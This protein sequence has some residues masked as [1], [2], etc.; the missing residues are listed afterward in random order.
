MRSLR[1]WITRLLGTM[2]GQRSDRDLELELRLHVELAEEQARRRADDPADAARTARL[3]TGNVPVAMDALRDQRGLPWLDA[4]RADVVFGWRQLKRHRAATAAAILSLGLAIGATTAAFR[5]VDALLLRPLPVA[6]PD[7]LFAVA[8]TFLDAGKQIDTRD[9]FDYPTYRDYSSAVGANAD[10]MVIGL[11]A[12]QPV[13]VQAGG[14]PEVALRQYMSGNAF[15]TLGLSPALGR[16]L[17]PADDVTPGGH[18]VAVLSYDYWS[19]R[20]N[21]DPGVIGKTLLAGS[22]S[23]EIVGVAPRGFTGTEPGGVTDFFLPA[24]M[25]AQALNSP[26]WSWFRMWVRPRPGVGE[27]QVRAM[28]DARY[29]ANRAASLKS[30]PADT[31]QARID[32]YLAEEVRLVPAGSGVSALQKTFR[33][34]LLI[35]GAL[36]A[37]VLLVACANVANLLAG[38]AAA[39]MREMALR[40]SIGAGRW[41][42]IQLV[43]VESLLL[44][45]AASI[46]G[47]MFAAWSAPLVVA[48]LAPIE[49]P[50]RLI[51]D[52]DWRALGFGV[53]LAMAVGAALWTRA[54]PPRVIRRSGRRA[55]RRESSRPTAADERA[56]RRANGV[57]HVP[58]RRG[59]V[60]RRDVP[61]TSPATA[62]ILRSQPARDAGRNAREPVSRDMDADCRRPAPDDWRPVGRLGRLGAADRQSL[63]IGGPSGGWRLRPEFAA[64]RRRL[65]RLLRDDGDDHGARP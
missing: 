40:V 53:S 13:T 60:V 22:L 32:E 21:R 7:R 48:M 20:F 11:L 49:R 25:N 62:G 35:V 18:P 3:I 2:R 16:L 1:E 31:P 44:A 28:L 43:L 38:Q 14:D 8:T 29:R 33:R 15:A 50:I 63:A 51:L 55:E 6:A 42:L 19:R 26:G 17:G 64:F 41:R 34:P 47:M 45:V 27:D 30:L 39:R 46:A 59:R 52:I 24:M 61:A 37:L 9:D 4:L 23:L 5:L 36:A 10:L 58:S 54:R 12:R 65:T 57:L 56:D